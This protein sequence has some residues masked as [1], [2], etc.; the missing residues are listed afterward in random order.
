MKTLFAS[1]LLIISFSALSEDS[2]DCHL[3]T[4]KFTVEENTTLN[5][6]ITSD[7]IIITDHRFDSEVIVYEQALAVKTS[8]RSGEWLTFENDELTL[9]SSGENR[10]LYFDGAF[11]CFKVL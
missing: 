6:D 4:G 8:T 3:R 2:Y 9:E 1:F 10:R 11:K 7:E 5:L